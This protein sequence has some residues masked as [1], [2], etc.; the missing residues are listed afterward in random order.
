MLINDLK[1]VHKPKEVKR[2]ARGGKRGTYS[3]RG[4]KGQRSRAGAKIKPQLREYIIR[5]PKIRGAGFKKP[6]LEVL[7]VKLSDLKKKLPQ[8]GE[9]TPSVLEKLGLIE[10]Q[11]NKNY[12]IK[13]LGKADLTASYNISNCFVSKTAQES[14]LKAGGKIKIK[15]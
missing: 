5:L 4:Q 15:K 1:P 14:I 2:I 13:I 10:R 8:G 3:G 9:V 6:N 7:E 11:S 12:I